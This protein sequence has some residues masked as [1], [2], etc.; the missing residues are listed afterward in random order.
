MKLTRTYDPVEIRVLGA[1]LE[2]QQTTPEYY[3]MT[4]NSLIA[5]CN[6]KSNRFP[7]TEYSEEQI[8][9]ALDNLQHQVL[10][11]KVMGARTAHWKHNL[12]GPLE[13]DGPSKAILTMLL[14]RGP[15]TTGELR[16]RTERLHNFPTIEEI[17]QVLL[18]M[19]ADS[20]PLIVEVPRQTGRKESRWM[21]LLEGPVPRE[22]AQSASSPPASTRTDSLQRIEQLENR[23]SK[24]EE[25][26][27]ELKEKLGE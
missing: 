24:V 1:L 27:R 10:V 20:D 15:Q 14:L 26:L 18:R 2:K 5:A 6:Q 19:A 11:W 4:L 8:S 25:V 21:H 7:V 12:D 3:P 13:L 23:L 17:E 9:A 16:G 22:A